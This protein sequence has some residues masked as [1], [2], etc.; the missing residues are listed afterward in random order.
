MSE[1]RPLRESTFQSVSKNVGVKLE[2]IYRFESYK[3]ID[4]KQLFRQK[5]KT[6]FFL[7]LDSIVFTLT[8]TALGLLHKY[9]DECKVKINTWSICMTIFSFAS[10]IVNLFQF[11]T[12]MQ[13]E[14]YF[15]ESE[16]KQLDL[17]QSP[18][19]QVLES[20]KYSAAFFF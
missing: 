16:K 17:V 11:K 6:V 20:C 18:E 7:V 15:K 1:S 10:I 4:E 19:A 2:K 8:I 9:W 12:I 5:I 3:S 14:K 13:K